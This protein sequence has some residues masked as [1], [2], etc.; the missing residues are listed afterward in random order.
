AQI[1]TAEEILM[2]PANDYV[3]RFVEDV[4]LSKVLTAAHVMKRAESIT[5]DRGP[6]VALEVM[7]KEGVSTVYVT[8]KAKRL[9]GYVTADQ[10]SEAVKEGKEISDVL[11]SDI[12]NI[13]PE[14]LLNDIL[15]PLSEATAPLSVV[16][17]ENKLKGIVVRGAI[18]GALS[19]NNEVINGNGGEVINEGK[20]K[21]SKVY[22]GGRVEPIAGLRKG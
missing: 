14:T 19:G 21:I 18:M 8:D 15:E 17:E 13:S 11:T 7:R 22:V 12:P 4:D 6:R 20:K 9:L 3:E 5:V 10:A 2:D 16:D 1:G